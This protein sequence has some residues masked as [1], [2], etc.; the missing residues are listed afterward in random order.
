MGLTQ[1]M[2]VFS[3]KVPEQLDRKLSAAAKRRGLRKSA[4]DQ[5][6]LEQNLDQ[7]RDIREK[8]FLE[9]DGDIVGCVKDAP[10]DLSSKPQRFDGYGL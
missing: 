10:A 5:L 3:M 1:G 8:S 2:K 6:A 7:S 9:L 4:V